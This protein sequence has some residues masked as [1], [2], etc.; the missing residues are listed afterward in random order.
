MEQVVSS[1]PVFDFST[2]DSSGL[3]E[4]VRNTV[5]VFKMVKAVQSARGV[6]EGRTQS[7]PPAPEPTQAPALAP[8][9]PSGS[10]HMSADSDSPPEQVPDQSC[11][12]P[13]PSSSGPT[14][15]DSPLLING[16]YSVEEYQAIYHSVVDPMLTCVAPISPSTSAPPPDFLLALGLVPKRPAADSTST[17]PPAKRHNFLSTSSCFS[18]NAK[19][20]IED[21]VNIFCVS[22]FACPSHI[23]KNQL[24]E[25]QPT[26]NIYRGQSSMLPFLMLQPSTNIYRGQTIF[27]P[28][29]RLLLMPQPTTNIYRG[30]PIFNLHVAFF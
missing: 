18:S 21:T 29:C 17:Q 2:L 4:Q 6:K 8:A 10:E 13:A 1:G 26:T 3:T 30:Q 5:V 24:P 25:P 9:P 14:A 15:P 27:Q 16:H 7:D 20:T 22:N 12:D 19:V 28:P 11:P 23:S